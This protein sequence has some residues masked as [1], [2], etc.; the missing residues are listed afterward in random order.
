MGEH[1]NHLE[2]LSKHRVLGATRRVLVQCLWVW[3]QE[4]A[5]LA[6][7]SVVALLVENYS[8]RIP[9]VGISSRKRYL[10]QDGN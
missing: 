5:F 3:V 1:Q 6:G 10:E 8:L 7:S 9:A 4:S 2:G